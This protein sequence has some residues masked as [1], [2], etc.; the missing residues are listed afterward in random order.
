MREKAQ[1]MTAEDIRRAL[2][3]ISHEILERNHREIADLVLIGIKSRG[4]YLA[5]RIA[6][7]LERIENIN[8]PV[9]IIDARLYR[10]DVNLH[11]EELRVNRTDIPFDVVGKRVILVDEVIYTGRTIRAAMDAVI[12]FGRPAAIQLAVLIDRGHR[13]LPIAADY[14]GKNVPTSRRELIRVQLVEEHGIDC[15]VICEED[16]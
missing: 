6:E 12:D 11:D 8:I 14:V 2:V 3:R 15:A 10:D 1:V 16:G 5:H 13:E 4:D 7:N 9:G